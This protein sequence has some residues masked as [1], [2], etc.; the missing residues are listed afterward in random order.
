MCSIIQNALW[1]ITGDCIRLS[2][3]FKLSL[4]KNKGDIIRF[5]T[6]LNTDNLGDYII[7]RY[8]NEA[9]SEIYGNN[10]FTDISTHLTPTSTQEEKVMQTKLKFV[11][12]TNILTSHI[13]KYWSWCLPDGLRRKLKY[14]NVILLGVG[15]KNYEDECSKYSKMIY[16]SILNPNI[17]HSVRDNYTE[18]MLKSAGVCNV[19]NT[20]CPTMWRLTPEF[21]KDIPKKKSRNVITTITDYRRDI[22]HDNQMLE[23][24]GRNYE[25]VYLWLQGKY[26]EEYLSE[27]TVPNNFSTIPASMETYEQYLN[28][29]DVDYV[30]TRL[31]AGIFALNHHVRSLVIAVDNRAV[32]IAKDT[33]LPVIDRSD[34]SKE[35][36]SRILSEWSTDI[37]INQHN[38]ELFKSQFHK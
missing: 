3:R 28:M 1:R 38:I 27:L 25:N 34:L 35:L 9:L 5:N 16:K 2:N 31:H 8:C 32:E 12:G 18:K 4:Q 23:I 21:C 33:N 15:W 6:A 14:R 13:E 30:G 10:E 19:I 26:D 37:R 17:L 7:M 29:D 22:E 36:E 20:G 24:L 11:C